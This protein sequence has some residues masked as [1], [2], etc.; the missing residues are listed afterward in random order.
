MVYIVNS[1]PEKDIQWS[2]TGVSSSN[3]F[4]QNLD[5]NYL[6][7]QK[8]ATITD[9]EYLSAKISSFVNKIDKAIKILDL[10]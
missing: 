3:K 5:L 8:N 10:M 7:S 9:N 1:P 2:N 4:L 6:I